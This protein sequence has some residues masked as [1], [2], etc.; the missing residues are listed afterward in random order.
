MT[1]WYRL[2]GAKID[3]LPEV[4]FEDLSKY[5]S[6]K[7]IDRK[8]I[9]VIV[10]SDSGKVRNGIIKYSTVVVVRRENHGA[11]AYWKVDKEKFF[12]N[13]S[14]NRLKLLNE[15][16]KSLDVAI[17][18]EPIL[19]SFG[20]KITNI[21]ADVNNKEIHFSNIVYDEIMGLIRAHG[22]NPIGKPDCWAAHIVAHNKT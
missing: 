18:L 15:A 1:T 10:G 11:L 7:H 22:F 13:L 8:S 3:N 14:K 17:W 16:Q 9:S 19:N 12:G 21:H 2:S 5:Y 20:L 4:I 6:G